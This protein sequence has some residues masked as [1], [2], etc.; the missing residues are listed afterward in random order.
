MKLTRLILVAAGIFLAWCP[1]SAFAAFDD[2]GLR[3]FLS[4]SAAGEGMGNAVGSLPADPTNIWTNPGGLAFQKGWKLY[5]SP[6]DEVRDGQDN[7]RDRVF[8]LAWG[9]DDRN[10]FGAALILRDQ[11][12]LGFRVSGDEGGG[13]QATDILEQSLMLSYARRLGARFGVGATVIGYQQTATEEIFE[14]EKTFA[15]TAGLL[16]RFSKV[17]RNQYPYEIRAGLSLANAG[18]S[19]DM[20][21]TESDLP[22]YARLSSSLNYDRNRGSGFTLAADLYSHLRD[23]EVQVENDLIEVR[24]WL[25]RLGFGIGGE[26]RIS[27]VAAIRGGYI[28][29]DDIGTGGRS[30]GTF[31]FGVGHQVYRGVGGMFEYSRA[32]AT[33]DTA[34]HIGFRIYLVPEYLGRE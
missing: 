13:V 17:Y 27:G 8:S 7:L 4:Y 28:W 1:P 23:R 6:D 29:D 3:P 16:A 15:V 20:G 34:D 12:R 26:L 14:S 22:L 33:T 31:G 9:M 10:T 19:F 2:L 25:Q 30:G 18:P 32:P 24:D 21:N 11:D 5:F